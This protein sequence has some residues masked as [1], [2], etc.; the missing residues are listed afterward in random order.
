[1][2]ECGAYG[3]Q[4]CPSYPGV[5]AVV[6]CT[7]VLGTEFGFCETAVCALNCSAIAPASKIILNGGT[8]LLL[9]RKLEEVK[10]KSN[11]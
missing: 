2:C 9:S 3:G 4:K 6:S 5:E 7:G 10:I 8:L 11:V 1:M